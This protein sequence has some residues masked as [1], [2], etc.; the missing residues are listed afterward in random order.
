[1]LELVKPVVTRWNSYYSAFERAT[2]LQAA[3][4]LYAEHHYNKPPEA[5]DWMRLNGLTAADW[6]IIVEYQVY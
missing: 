6:A 3:Y 2:K 5:P 1:M 4:N